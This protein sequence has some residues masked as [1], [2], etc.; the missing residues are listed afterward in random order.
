MQNHCSKTPTLM[1][2]DSTQQ[3]L[4]QNDVLI[5]NICH[6]SQSIRFNS[7]PLFS[8]PWVS[9]DP[10]GMHLTK[11]LHS[12]SLVS[13]MVI[14]IWASRWLA[15]AHMWLVGLSVHCRKPQL[16]W[17]LC[18]LQC[19]MGSQDILFKG[20]WQSLAQPS[21]QANC[22]PWGLSKGTVK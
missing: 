5:T 12:P 17:I 10:W 7:S 6:Q 20:P 11:L 21:W 2:I 16:Q 15:S 8:N 3:L 18:K 22:L 13:K 14:G 9:L 4:C 1:I 19:I